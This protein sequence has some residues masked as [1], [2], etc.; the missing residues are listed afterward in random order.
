MKT[1]YIQ[2]STIFIY[3]VSVV[4]NS[5]S[6]PELHNICL[7]HAL[8]LPISNTFQTCPSI[9]RASPV[10]PEP[11]K[12]FQIS[13]QLL[14]PNH[15]PSPP[16]H[17]HPQ[18]LCISNMCVRVQIRMPMQA[19]GGGR[20][21]TDCSSSSS[22]QARNGVVA[23][24]TPTTT[25]SI[26]ATE[27]SNAA[28]AVTVTVFASVFTSML[29]ISLCEPVSVSDSAV[30]SVNESVAS[31][32]FVIVPRFLNLRSA[33]A[34]YFTYGICVNVHLQTTSLGRH[35][36]CPRTPDTFCTAMSPSARWRTAFIL[37]L[38]QST[39]AHFYGNCTT[40]WTV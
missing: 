1:N 18:D 2:N 15:E 19:L 4:P 13:A 24:P 38:H 34:T 3:L 11:K 35:W 26:A 22:T 32:C 31:E 16:A 33:N 21:G 20:T 9:S 17:A 12:L 7:M 10:F 28:T 37:H 25:P 6:F 29:C 30:V 5:H 40:L 8:Q 23:T 14:T 39:V 36:P 27:A